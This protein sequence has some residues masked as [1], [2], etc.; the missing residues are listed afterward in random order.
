M[1]FLKVVSSIFL[2]LFPVKLKMDF[3]LPKKCIIIGAPHTS[4][5]DGVL[6]VIALWQTK[7]K[8][9]FLV[10]NSAVNSPFGPLIKAVGG[11]SVDR[12]VKHGVVDE[13]VRATKE[14]DEFLLILAPK[15]TRAKRDYWKSGFYHMAYQAD[16][17]VVLGYID[18]YNTHTCGWGKLLHLTGD[19]KA[20]MDLI[21][22]FYAD[23]TGWNPELKSEPRLRDEDNKENE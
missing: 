22:E 12:S 13:V 21:R 14:A 20:D 19:M 10:K 5:W 7:R 2:P 1:G 18:R 17:P 11:L 16:I 4:Y 8:F 9:K 15:G 3:P 6:M 23:K